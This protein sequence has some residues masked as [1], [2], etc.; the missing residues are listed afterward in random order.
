MKI[1]DESQM[2]I[3]LTLMNHNGNVSG[4][5]SIDTREKTPPSNK[6][7]PKKLQEF[8]YHISSFP[9]YKSHYTFREI[10]YKLYCEGKEKSFSRGIYEHEF[11]KMN[12]CFNEPKVDMCHRCGVLQVKA[13]FATM[14]N[15]AGEDIN[16]ELAVHHMEADKDK[17]FALSDN[18]LLCYMFDLQQCLPSPYSNTLV[19]FY[20]RF[21]WTHNLTMHETSI[22]S[23]TCFMWHETEGAQ[24]VSLT[25]EVKQVTLYSD[26][27]GGQNKNSHVS[28]MSLFAM[29]KNQHLII[30]DHKFLVK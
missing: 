24:L 19:S 15:T 8:N 27:C 18:S 16:E 6:Y 4:I 2:F 3:T 20:E 25:L 13:K 23:V 22:A 10:M 5:S 26:T 30:V 28:A 9:L 29:Q 1:I 21:P 7:T 12:I 17:K 14:N 11:H